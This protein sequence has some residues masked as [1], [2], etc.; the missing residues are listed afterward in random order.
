MEDVKLTQEE[1]EILASVE[2]DEWLSV[3]DLEPEIKRYQSYAKAHTN[4]I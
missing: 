2:N 3:P 4:P 1:Q